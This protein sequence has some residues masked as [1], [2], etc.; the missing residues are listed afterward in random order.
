MI[1][2]VPVFGFDYL[3]QPRYVLFYQ[4]NLAALALMVYRDFRFALAPRLRLASGTLAAA[5][6]LALFGLQFQLS[7][8]AWEHAKFLSIY[9]D[10]VSK[11]MGRLAADP[12]AEMECAD[13]M[14]IC[15]FPPE[16]RRELMELLA[17]HQLNLFSPAFQAFHRLEPGPE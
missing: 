10:G 13:I 2:R 5:L 6:V 15:E 1:Q 9:V 17:R 14:T 8:L 12:T 4:L 11:T 7:V 3:H 16:K